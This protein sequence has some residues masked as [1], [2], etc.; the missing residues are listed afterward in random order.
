MG[1]KVGLSG[2]LGTDAG[3]EELRDLLDEQGISRDP[4]TRAKHLRNRYDDWFDSLK[5]P[6]GGGLFNPFGGL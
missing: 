6:W 2:K 4:M 3:A 1:I 5:L